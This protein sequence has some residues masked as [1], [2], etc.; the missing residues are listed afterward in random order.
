MLLRPNFILVAAGSCAL[1]L[2]ILT[3]FSQVRWKNYTPEHDT[4]EPS[5]SLE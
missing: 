4:W 5:S 2:V 1:L 3:F